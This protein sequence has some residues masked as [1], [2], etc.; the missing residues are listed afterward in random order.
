MCGQQNYLQL[1]CGP[2][3]ALCCCTKAMYMYAGWRAMTSAAWDALGCCSRPPRLEA[4]AIAR[5]RLF[6]R[7]MIRRPVVRSL[8]GPHL[9]ELAIARGQRG[10][11]RCNTC[12][13]VGRTTAP[14]VARRIVAATLVLLLFLPDIQIAREGSLILTQTALS[15]THA[16]PFSICFLFFPAGAG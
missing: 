16:R 11:G 8:H 5:W 14:F 4:R 6:S 10:V 2:Y 13:R 3:G 12:R 1:I 15:T 9:S 7:R